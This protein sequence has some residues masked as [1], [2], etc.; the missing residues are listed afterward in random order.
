MCFVEIL[1]HV[2]ISVNYLLDVDRRMMGQ[3]CSCCDS[4]LKLTLPNHYNVDCLTKRYVGAKECMDEM[5]QDL[6]E[7]T[8][9]WSC[10]DTL[11][12]FVKESKEVL[13]REMNIDDL[14]EQSKNQVSPTRR[15]L[16]LLAMPL[17]IV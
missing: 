13:W 2:S 16:Q 7:M 10:F 8:K 5:V 12:K 1:N 3:C 14:D 11:Q 6:A 17:A 4:V 15:F 9:V